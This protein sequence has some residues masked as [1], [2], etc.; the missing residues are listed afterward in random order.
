[1]ADALTN[2]GVGKESSFHAEEIVDKMNSPLWEKC[3]ALVGI[4]AEWNDEGQ[5]QQMSMPQHPR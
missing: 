3:E 5:P 4:N 1:M 2:E